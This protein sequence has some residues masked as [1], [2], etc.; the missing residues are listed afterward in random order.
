[1]KDKMKFI[2]ENAPCYIY[3]E[4]LIRERC[5]ALRNAMPSKHQRNGNQRKSDSLIF[6]V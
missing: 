5:M 6:N 4:A 1:M 2:R 3:E